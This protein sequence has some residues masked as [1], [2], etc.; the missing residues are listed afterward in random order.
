M[1]KKFEQLKEWA[2]FHKKE[3]I[4]AAVIFLVACLSF[5]LGYLANREFNHAPIIIEQNSAARL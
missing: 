5:G 4:F 1:T 2:V 3:I